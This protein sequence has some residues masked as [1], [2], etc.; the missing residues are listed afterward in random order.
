[1]AIHRK[2]TARALSYS[3][4][5]THHML[6]NDLGLNRSLTD[7]LSRK[8]A[9]LAPRMKLSARLYRK[10]VNWLCQLAFL[11]RKEVRIINTIDAIEKRHLAHRK[12]N[13]L[14]RARSLPKDIYVLEPSPVKPKSRNGIFWLFVIM[15][16]FDKPKPK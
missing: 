5:T 6:A 16:L 2:G 10:L 1:M 13:K 9:L 8:I 4:Q 7:I 14:M 3:P 12:M 15:M 11:K